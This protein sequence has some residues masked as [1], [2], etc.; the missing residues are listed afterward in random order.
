MRGDGPWT[1]LPILVDYT[2][3]PHAR[4]WSQ[5]GAAGAGAVVVSPACAGM[6]P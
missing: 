6:V 4:G 1:G 5:P 3:P 2:F